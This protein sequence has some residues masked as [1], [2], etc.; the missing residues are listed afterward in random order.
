M[1]QNTTVYPINMWNYFVSIF[2]V[3]KQ[4]REIVLLGSYYRKNIFGKEICHNE[5][6]IQDAKVTPQMTIS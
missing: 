4:C 6:T 1:Y 3:T 2:K 5:T